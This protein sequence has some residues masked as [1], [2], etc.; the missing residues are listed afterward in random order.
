MILNKTYGTIEDLVYY[1]DGSAVNGIYSD[2]NARITSNGDYITLDTTSSGEKHIKYPVSFLNEDN[3][4]LEYTFKGG[5]QQPVALIV[6]NR[7]A[8]GYNGYCSYDGSRWNWSFGS[9]SQKTKTI[10]DG[11]KITLR[12][13]DE[14]TQLYVNNEQLFS[15]AHTVP[16]AN[17]TFGH[18]VNSGRVQKLK[19]IKIKRL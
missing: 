10:Y 15:T 11:D 3:I 19:D 12:R 5:T 6:G 17:A 13:G 9:S 2:N 7:D 8:T 14:Y 1:N 18:Y 4:Q 16:F